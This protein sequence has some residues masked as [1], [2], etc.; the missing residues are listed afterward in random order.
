MSRGGHKTFPLLAVRLAAMA[1]WVQLAVWTVQ[2]PRI[3]DTIESK[4]KSPLGEE[5]AR[6][7]LRFVDRMTRWKWFVIRRNCLKKNLLYYY[8]LV[9]SGK[10]GVALHVGVRKPEAR[11]DGHCWLT[12][13]GEIFMDTSENVS[14]YTIMYSRGV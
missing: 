11:I 12:R 5:E 2:L 1:V 14:K 7:A 9:T 8:V 10:T 4:P 13:N 6:F 3:L